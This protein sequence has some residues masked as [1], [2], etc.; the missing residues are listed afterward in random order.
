MMQANTLD[1][2][3]KLDASPFDINQQSTKPK[4]KDLL[5][6]YEQVVVKSLI[7]SF[8][9][10]MFIKD[11][12][13]GN[14]DTLH[15]ARDSTVMD[16]ANKENQEAYD[17]RGEYNSNDYHSHENYKAVNR[18]NSNAKKNGALQD[19]Y[20]G[21]K[22]TINANMDLDH[23]ISAK[24][25]HDDAARVLARKDGAQLAN[26]DSNLNTTDRSV[27]RSKKAGSVDSFANKLDDTRNQ[28]QLRIN[29]LQRVSDITDKERKE[30]NKLEKLEA[31]NIEK[32]K[33]ID[34]KAREQ[35]NNSLN[36]YYTSAAFMKDTAKASM[37][38][39]AQMGLRQALGVLLTEVWFTVKEEFPKIVSRMR[40]DFSLGDFLKEIGETFKKAIVNVQ[41]KNKEII[42]SFKDGVLS[43]IMSSL[44]T[45]F[46]NIFFTTAKN[47]GRII[48]ESWASIVEAVRILVFNPDKLPFG[49]VLRSVAKIVSTCVA[50][51]L[52]ITVQEA[53]SKMPIMNI[54]VI[55]EIV[56][57]FL[58]T[59][60]T[61][62]VSITMLYFFD[63]STIVQ[64]TVDF[65]NSLKSRADLALDYY[66]AV[67]EELSRYVA[68]LAGIDY[69]ALK[70][71]VEK[72]QDINGRLEN[73]TTV[74][75]LN[76]V[77]T[78]VVKEMD[79]QLPYED[80]DGLKKFMN[81]KSAVLVFE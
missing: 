41:L 69:V 26:H 33:E 20:S 32:I 23:T 72:L 64:K 44:V 9:L 65:A 77:L 54:P 53:V 52:G 40:T 8:G 47:V 58:G 74:L 19:S 39:G 4:F 51:I 28:R 81:D 56:P 38:K 49:E 25:I 29:E 3:K 6:E 13:G 71:E 34:E 10:D 63:H 15:T 76:M 80:L 5:P 18:R 21:K 27:N 59:L 57:I 37:K 70:Q 46:T 14:V 43:G 67:N 79:I 36:S 30:L 22:V 1:F 31:V 68:K 75:Q 11:R 7:T 66:Q 35:Y 45:T 48:R 73:A 78:K 16:Y 62:V 24:E 42:Q 61:G 60:T 2:V 12:R 55:E 50:V 17:S